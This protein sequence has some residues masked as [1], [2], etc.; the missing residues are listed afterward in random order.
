MVLIEMHLSKNEKR[1]IILIRTASATTHYEF[2]SLSC[3]VRL[4]RYLRLL[5]NREESTVL[6]REN[7]I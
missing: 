7:F 5:E 1:R 6:I 3:F 4:T 2:V